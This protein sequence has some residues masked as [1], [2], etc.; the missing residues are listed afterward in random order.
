MFVDICFLSKEWET[1]YGEVKKSWDFAIVSGGDR[2]IDRKNNFWKKNSRKFP[3]FFKKNFTTFFSN[4]QCVKLCGITQLKTTENQ[5]SISQLCTNTI[6]I[7][8]K[9]L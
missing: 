7:A 4:E 9:Y 5:M 8:K 1:N 3:K 6:F 2:S